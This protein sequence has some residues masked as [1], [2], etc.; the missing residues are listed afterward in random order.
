MLKMLFVQKGKMFV[1]LK[2]NYGCPLSVPKY[3]FYFN[4]SPYLVSL[5]K[6]GP[7]ALQPPALP[8]CR[9]PPPPHAASP[10]QR[11]G[12]PATAPTPVKVRPRTS[13]LGKKLPRWMTSPASLL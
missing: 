5:P 9:T 4:F 8:R 10:L 13:I 1:N 7:C 2:L 12:G 6:A 11:P 3:A